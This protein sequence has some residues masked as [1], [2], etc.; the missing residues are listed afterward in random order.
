VSDETREQT[1]AYMLEC[2]AR[3]LLKTMTKE[4]RRAYLASAPVQGRR[5]KLEAEML[6][7]YK[8]KDDR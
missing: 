6:R 8:A 4:Q 2:E 3:W 1:M 5:A 7:Q